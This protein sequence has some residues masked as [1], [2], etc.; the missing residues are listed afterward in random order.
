M[1][2]HYTTVLLAFLAV[3]FATGTKAQELL[4]NQ[5]PAKNTVLFLAPV[6]KINPKSS[7]VTVPKTVFH[8]PWWKLDRDVI[9]L[10]LM[11]GGA[12]LMDGITT[13]QCPSEF[14]ETDPLDRL[15]LGQR[16]TWSRMIPLGSVEIFGTALLAQH[17]K[18]SKWKI[19]RQLH[20]APQIFFITQHTYEGAHNVIET[21]AFLKQG[22]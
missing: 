21:N 5:M 19:V 6:P 2:I 1:R 12:S 7:E 14:S 13:R 8:A 16:P 11:H 15:F 10:G 22:Y 9:T 4:E 17:M 3:N 18:H 20:S